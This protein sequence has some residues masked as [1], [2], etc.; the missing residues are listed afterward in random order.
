MVNSFEWSK[1]ES[2]FAGVVPKERFTTLDFSRPRKEIALQIKKIP[3]PTPTISDILDEL[4]IE[5]SVPCSILKPIFIGRIIVGPALTIRYVKETYVP[6]QSMIDS[7]KGN[8][9][10]KDAYAIAQ[11]GDVVI[12]DN[13]GRENISTLGSLS[14]RYAITAEIEG[15]IV[16]GGIRDV[17]EIK[18]LGFAV[19][20]RGITPISG[21]RRV[22]TI[23]IN[24]PVTCGGI[25]VVPG[26][27]VVADDNGVCFIPVNKIELVFKLLLERV[28]A[29]ERLTKALKDGYKME[30]MRK[31]IS[32]DRW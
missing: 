24:G 19:W 5:G 12:F 10:D 4:G 29:E 32:P 20:S 16:D 6:K 25:K 8:L 23:E 15:C 17:S 18:Q 9:G 28:M 30:E 31:I 11:P 3:D 27:L 13:G 1:Y 26:D 14:V 21:K 7:L 22:E 2:K